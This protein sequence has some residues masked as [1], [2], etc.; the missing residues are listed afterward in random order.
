MSNTSAK[1]EKSPPSFP[2]AR[3]AV[4]GL[5]PPAYEKATQRLS[6]G[7]SLR[8]AVLEAASALGNGGND[9]V[10]FDDGI[11]N[12]LIHLGGSTSASD[13]SAFVNL[14]SRILPKNVELSG[15]VT[16]G[17]QVVL[18]WLEQSRDV[19]ATPPGGVVIDQPVENID[20]ND[21]V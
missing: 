13:R 14:L 11:R 2:P 15:D 9:G 10:S 4:F 1:T 12:Y 3:P 7:R 17:V 21:D 19:D 5:K 16:T 18:P 20:E 8:K 6:A